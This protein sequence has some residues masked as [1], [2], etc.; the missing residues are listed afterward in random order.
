MSI[1]DSSA[2]MEFQAV[3]QL[4]RQSGACAWGC[5]PLEEVPPD[6]FAGYRQWL[7]EGRHA[8]MGYLAD[9]LEIRRNP[10]LLLAHGREPQPGGTIIS[11]AYPYYSG[12]PYRPGKLKIARYALGDD[13]HDSLRRR[14]RPVAEAITASTGLEARICVD[15][16]PILERYWARRS[17]MGFT[18]R[19]RQFIVPGAGSYVFLAEIVTRAVFPPGSP[20]TL[21]CG[22]CDACIRSCPNQALGATLDSRRCLSY[23]TIEHRGALPA[24]ISVPPSR[25][26]GCDICLE[27]CPMAR[28]KGPDT[29]EHLP[30]FTPRETL[31][32]L[33]A[34]NLLSLTPDSFSLMFRKSAVKRTRLEGMQRN[35]DALTKS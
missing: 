6:V 15:T 22:G 24:G 14:L 32:S 28:P 18:G 31:L 20:C 25:V 10:A 19:N 8:S 12:N 11:V 5:S 17:G 30:E 1:Q 3:E 29:V 35:A 27:V 16:A 34:A 7:E 33:T 4:L 13:Y 26:Y 21:T 9:H 2:Q 23:L